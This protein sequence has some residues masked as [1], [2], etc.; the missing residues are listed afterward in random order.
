MKIRRPVQAGKFYPADAESLRSQ[1][2]SCFV[3]RYGPGKLPKIQKGKLKTVV[4]LVCPHAGYVYSGPVAAN[5]YW[6]IGVD[7]KPDTIVV[8]GPNHTGY[9]S[10]IALM[11]QG[12]WRTPLGDVEIDSEVANELTKETGILDVDE[13]AHRY[14][15][16]IEVQLPFLQYMYADAF[17]LVPI[18]FR[19]Q[20]LVSAYE[21][22]NALTEV[23]AGRNAVIIASSDFT[24]YEPEAKAS[25]KDKSALEAVLAM[26][27]MKFMSII[28]SENVT[29]CGYG[30]IATMMTAAKGLLATKTKLLSYRTSGD[31]TEDRS[32]VVG[33]AAVAFK[34]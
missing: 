5:S 12:A 18:C 3:H 25:Q 27:T 30:P 31:I 20:D 10:A 23:L 7:G 33:Y 14:E 32:S 15:H 11:N 28:E 6:E 22:G 21:V 2:E 13:T 24:H 29:A 26:D 16:S 1:I 19:M 17:K 34:K 8:L 4:G 9:G